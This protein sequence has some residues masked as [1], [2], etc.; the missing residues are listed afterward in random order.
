MRVAVLGASGGTG[1][2]ARCS[3]TPARPP[4]R[5]SVRDPDQAA[6]PADTRLDR[7]TG[8]TCTTRLL[9]AAAIA[10]ESVVIS[11]P[12]VKAKNEAGIPHRLPHAP[13]SP[14]TRR[15]SCGSARLAPAGSVSAVGRLYLHACFAPKSAPNTTTRSPPTPRCSTRA[16]TPCCTP[17]RSPTR[18]TTRASAPCRSRPP[19]AGSSRTA[20]PRATVAR[21]M[22]R[23]S[24]GPSPPSYPRSSF[25][26]P[27][28]IRYFLEGDL[29]P[30]PWWWP[31]HGAA[32]PRHTAPPSG[33]PAAA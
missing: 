27:E 25:R 8:P 28:W 24:R 4:G 5:R 17:A 30:F 31:P 22:R 29:R 9:A 20:R 3:G 33:T 26:K 21:L 11:G 16:A 12:G 14:R 13:S 6:L 2:Q 15:G 1:R 10:P 7:S 23:R 18:P 19:A 32:P